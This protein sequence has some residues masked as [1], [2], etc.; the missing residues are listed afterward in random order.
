MPSMKTILS[1]LLLASSLVLPS[2]VV[3]KT[4]QP[5]CKKGVF[6][7][8][9]YLTQKDLRAFKGDKADKLALRNPHAIC[10]C[11]DDDQDTDCQ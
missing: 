11:E 10:Q 9:P 4:H 6:K 8:F 2:V 5:V 7:V 1:S 3:A